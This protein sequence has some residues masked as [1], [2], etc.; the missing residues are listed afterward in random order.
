MSKQSRLDEL[1]IDNKADLA[2]R[3]TEL[4][5]RE[6]AKKDQ[7]IEQQRAIIKSL[8]QNI[9]TKMVANQDTQ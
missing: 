8:S 7:I 5:Q 3:T 4:N 1:G 6:M 2:E 9:M